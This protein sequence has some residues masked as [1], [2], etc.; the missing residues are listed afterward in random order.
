M[1][2]S[3]ARLQVKYSI[4]AADLPERTQPLRTGLSLDVSD[5]AAVPFDVEMRFLATDSSGAAE[6]CPFTML[7]AAGTISGYGATEVAVDFEP[8]GMGEREVDLTISLQ[9]VERPTLDLECLQ[10]HLQV[11]LCWITSGNAL[12]QSA[13][14]L[15][16]TLCSNLAESLPCLKCYDLCRCR[17]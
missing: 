5:P 15:G 8:V 3:M 2:Q 6:A 11:R 10:V 12:D 7:P 16:E 17:L 14:P 4:T 13:L 9:A 1:Q